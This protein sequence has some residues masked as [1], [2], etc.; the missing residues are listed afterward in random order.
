MK[1]LVFVFLVLV[2]F[3]SCSDWLDRE[4]S[5]II[6]PSQ[7]YSSRGSINSVIADLYYNL[8]DV[9][10]L[11]DVNFYTEWDEG[12]SG[13]YVSANN[14]ASYRGDYASFYNYALIRNIHSHLK[15][16]QN[17]KF[18]TA[19]EMKYYVAEA[20]FLR[21]YVYF[22][23]VK[24]MG[25]V[26]LIT[27]VMTPVSGKLPEEYETARSKEH[28][29][30]DFIASELD[31]VKEDLN[32][33]P[34]TQHNR[35]SKGAALAMKIRAMLYAGSLAGCNSEMAMPVSLAGGEV[36]IPPEMADGYFQKALDAFI[37]LENMGKYGLYDNNPDKTANF[38]EALT[39]E[40]RDNKEIIFVKD[41][42]TEFLQPW[43]SNNLSRTLRYGGITAGNGGSA[44]NPT[45]N[46]VDEF[47]R[48]DGS[49]PK[50]KAYV[51][52]NHADEIGPDGAMDT[53]PDAYVYYD[54]LSDIFAKKDPRLFATVITPG[55][56]FG[57]RSLDMRAGYAY[58]NTVTNKF[59]FEVGTFASATSNNFIVSGDTIKEA[60]GNIRLKTGND[61]PARD[62][63]V[64][65]TG[66]YVRKF[67]EENPKDPYFGSK[68]PSI[69]YR[70][71]EALLNAAEAA[72]ELGKL[73]EA[74]T[75]LNQIRERAGLP[76]KSAVTREDIRRERRVE[77]ALESGHRYFDVKRW[78]IA[79]ELFDGSTVSPT[80]M[81]Y[82]L[83]PYK[84][85]RPNHPTHDKWIF[86]R[87]V[88]TSVIE[89]PRKFILS[90][91]YS[92]IPSDAL[93]NNGKLVKNPGQ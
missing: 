27:E 59:Q 46:L 93:A 51:D 38:N 50:L 81:M 75:Y 22:E 23:M 54:N 85:Y 88:N 69:R 55:Q 5:N 20:R 41:F 73:A 82:G 87:R 70:Y 30:Y 44:C 56:L 42:S 43:T 62:A 72:F 89:N 68:I 57:G 45:L 48:T 52:S 25:G 92:F 32:L 15:D 7:A 60:N 13:G 53:N 28:E 67:M 19:D 66:F 64:S 90:N 18:L 6:T 84:V 14:I 47:E 31:A 39:K 10:G 4:P 11:Q 12:I 83:W 34:H 58:F 61:G 49:D 21:A 86:V 9:G 26:P 3:S 16:I 8:P 63:F 24:R 29:I 1:K 65:H 78:R 36:G 91:Y 33:T 37:E 77:L 74:A 80:A 76:P 79:H 71:G 17:V 40:A 35:A 2:S